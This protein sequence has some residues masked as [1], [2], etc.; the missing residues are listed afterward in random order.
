[1]LN[2]KDK[3]DYLKNKCKKYNLTFKKSEYSLINGLTCYKI[4]NSDGHTI[5]DLLTVN[6]AYDEEMQSGFIVELAIKH[7]N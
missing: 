6:S 5:R 4:V 7:T 2:N 3:L 1:M